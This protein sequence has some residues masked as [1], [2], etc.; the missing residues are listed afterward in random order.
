[1]AKNH[2]RDLAKHVRLLT[3]GGRALVQFLEDVRDGQ[4]EGATVRDR[5]EA[6]KLLLERGYGKAPLTVEVT[7]QVNH[8]HLHLSGGRVDLSRLT[9]QELLQIQATMTRAVVGRVAEEEVEEADVVAEEP[10]PAAG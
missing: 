4:V 8:A 6:T 1:V 7:G 9:P 10:D 3:G 5:L 2:V